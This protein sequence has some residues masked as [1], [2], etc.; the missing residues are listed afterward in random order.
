M[1]TVILDL[2]N[3]VKSFGS[4]VVVN[5]VSFAVSAGEFFTLLGPSG[6]GKTTTLRLLAGLE[7][8]DGGTITLDGRCLAAPDLGIWIPPDKRNVGMMF[9]SYAI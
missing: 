5:D 6:C 7:I 3:V 1:S 9:Q 8:P 4:N 2:S